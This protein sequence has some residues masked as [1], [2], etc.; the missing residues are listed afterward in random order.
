MTPLVAVVVTIGMLVVVPLGLRLVPEPGAR[1]SR[2]AVVWPMAAAPAAVA[3]WLPRGSVAAVLCTPYAV[4]AAFL[5]LEAG[6]RAWHLVAVRRTVGIDI[7]VGIAIVT[8]MA[9][10]LVAASA[11]VAERAGVALFGFRPPVL[12]LTV[13]HFHFAGFCAALVAGLAG[14]HA[15]EG[16]AV[17]ARPG[18]RFA[19]LSVPAGI[20]LVF[21]GFFV[22]A[23]VQLAGAVVLTAGM[24]CVAWALWRDLRPSAPDMLARA[25]T[26]TGAVVLPVTMLLALDWA[27]G[28]VVGLPHLSLAWMAATHGVCNAVG[29]ALCALLAFRRLSWTP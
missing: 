14:S 21:A 5:A 20:A 4:V 6:I 1:V 2:L 11:L 13:A 7:P 10:P 29:F 15:V 12:A 25:L 27:I 3:L 24:W 26:T 28:H 8:A 22:G 16:V 18:A 9:S 19:A 17:G 23:I